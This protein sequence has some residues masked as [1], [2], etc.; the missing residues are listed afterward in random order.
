MRGIS[1]ILLPITYLTAVLFGTLSPVWAERAVRFDDYTVHYNVLTTDIIDAEVARAY[2]IVRSNE[3]AMINVSVLK[4]ND[5]D[6][7]AQ[8]ALI[9]VV[10]SNLNS[11]LRQI[12]IRQLDDGDA[13]YYVGE[14]PV[15]HLETLTFDVAVTP[16]GETQTH[17]FN[18]S[19]QFY[20]K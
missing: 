10:A 4:A 9:K 12:P 2:G 11:Q 15:N 14:F 13:I 19:E 1:S 7:S 16:S 17:T 3:R 20:T 18:F 8:K 5:T 6:M